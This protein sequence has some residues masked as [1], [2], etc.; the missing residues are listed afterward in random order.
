[1]VMSKTSEMCRYLYLLQRGKILDT[2]RPFGT[3]TARRHVQKW[4][5]YY[6]FTEDALDNGRDKHPYSKNGMMI[7]VAIINR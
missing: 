4:R 1:M 3:Y 7:F 5:F 6:D 2:K